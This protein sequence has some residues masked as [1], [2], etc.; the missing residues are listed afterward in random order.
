MRQ[1]LVPVPGGA[2]VQYFAQGDACVWYFM[3]EWLRT[4]VCPSLS[5][6]STWKISSLLIRHETSPQ[7]RWNIIE[8]MFRHSYVNCNHEKCF[9]CQTTQL[10]TEFKKSSVRTESCVAEEEALEFH[11]RSSTYALSLCR[12]LC[13]SLRLCEVCTEN[14]YVS[15]KKG[16][17]RV[18]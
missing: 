9:E 3:C 16:N 1:H 6:H 10:F 8:I 17:A 2:L 18:S 12:P 7:V 13:T 11:L 15:L 4:R 5:N 14:L